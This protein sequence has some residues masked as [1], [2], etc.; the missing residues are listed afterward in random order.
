MKY[1]IDVPAGGKLEIQYGVIQA[2]IDAGVPEDCWR[3]P[4]ARCIERTMPGWGAE[5]DACEITLYP[6]EEDGTLMIEQPMYRA[7]SPGN[8]VSFMGDFDDELSVGPFTF[9]LEWRAVVPPVVSG[10]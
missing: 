7:Q 8:C 1:L 10:G 9:Q 2:D 4:I 5:V 6:L 3:C